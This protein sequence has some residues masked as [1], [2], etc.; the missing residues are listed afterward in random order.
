M[1]KAARFKTA[2]RPKDAVP[3]LIYSALRPRTVGRDAQGGTFVRLTGGIQGANMIAG[4][5]NLRV[6]WPA[7]DTLE[8][9]I[10]NE[11]P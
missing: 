8:R 6:L 2:S 7:I 10:L 9:R 3:I 4:T 11:L 1:R 5:G